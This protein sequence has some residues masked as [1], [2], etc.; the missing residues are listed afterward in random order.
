[1]T[2]LQEKILR[3]IREQGPITLAHYMQM[4]LLDPEH[5]Y[6]MKRD[7]LGRDFITAPEISQIFGELIGLFFAQAWEDRGRPGKF[8][9]VELGPGRGTLMADLL[10]AAAKVRPD[11]VA[12]AHVVLV[13]ASPV[14]RSIQAQMLGNRDVQWAGT[15][16]EVPDDAPLFLVA[17]EFFDALPAQQFVKTFDSRREVN[18]YERMVSAQGENLVFALAPEP[19]PSA[20]S[21]NAMPAAQLGAIFEIQPAAQA[22]V[23]DIAHR[24]AS[25]GGLGLIIDYGHVAGLGDTFQAIKAH[26]F[27]EPLEDPG[28]ADLTV[29]VDFGA[30]A[31]AAREEQAQVWGPITQAE[32]LEALGIRLR[33]ERLKRAAPEKANEIDAAIDRLIGKEQMGTLFK[34]L[35]LAAPNTPPLPGFPC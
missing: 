8:H 31:G 18:W 2:P 25:R 21:L 19:V 6:Y 3:L 13:E 9:L 4:S 35:A 11:F 15:F 24:V 12:A 28:E 29:H 17:N 20:L 14:L 10:R 7:P 34:V 33:G 5:G 26:A 16:A 1:V 22:I 23:S 32:F 30:L 27:V